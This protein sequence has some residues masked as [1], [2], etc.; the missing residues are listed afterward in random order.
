MRHVFSGFALVLVTAMSL[1]AS[2]Q[3]T[4]YHACS[5]SNP[6]NYEVYIYVDGNF[7][8]AC[9]ALNVGFYPNSGT[10]Y[11][12]FGLPNDSISSF[13][14]GAN[15]Y[16]RVFSDGGY[17]GDWGGWPSG[18]WGVITAFND[19]VSS[20]RVQDNSRSE[21]C[22]D[23]RPEEFA[24][25]RDAN[26]AN[27]CVVLQYF[28]NY[29]TP[30]TMGIANDSISAVLGGPE[31]AAPCPPNSSGIWSVSLW[32]N[33]WYGGSGFSIGSGTNVSYLSSFNDQASSITTSYFCLG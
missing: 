6:S 16:L 12:G 3:V 26:Y 4:Q 31:I 23:L 7:G 25:F 21:T 11:G 1:S 5:G 18:N 20:I 13:K 2:A 28:T 22:D 30:A 19:E 10:G 33:S 29:P 14:V 32:Q 17:G 8:G 24:L 27:D 9:A 15:V